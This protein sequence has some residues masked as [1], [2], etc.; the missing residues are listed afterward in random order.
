MSKA[1]SSKAGGVERLRTACAKLVPSLSYNNAFRD[2]PIRSM[3]RRT[4]VPPSIGM[5]KK[6]PLA[7][8]SEGRTEK[9]LPGGPIAGCHNCLFSRP[10]VRVFD[11]FT[12]SCF[13]RPIQHHM[14][15]ISTQ[16]KHTSSGTCFRHWSDDGPSAQPVIFRTSAYG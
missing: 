15:R 7:I 2:S 8:L 1:A 13:R 10:F 3:L 6:S 14:A 5:C 4:F 9:K 16:N 12:R 11:T